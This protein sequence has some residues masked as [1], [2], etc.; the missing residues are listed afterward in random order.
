MLSRTDLKT[1]LPW[2]RVKSEEEENKHKNANTENKLQFSP[3]RYIL[4]VPFVRPCYSVKPVA[5]DSTSHHYTTMNPLETAANDICEELYYSGWERIDE[6]IDSVPEKDWPLPG[7]WFTGCE[8][9]SCS[10]LHV[11]ARSNPP[12]YLLEKLVKVF[13]IEALS[14]SDD[15]FGNTP[16]HYMAWRV[17]SLHAL[18]LIARAHPPAVVARNKR[19]D[20]PLDCLF[21]R[22]RE[23]DESVV[24]QSFISL[25]EIYP[26]AIHDIDRNGR[27]W[28]HRCLQDVEDTDTLTNIIHTLL[29]AKTDL[30]EMADAS[31]MIAL[32]SALERYNCGEVVKLLLLHT[33]QLLRS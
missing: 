23:A 5:L 19:F 1:D 24:A 18:E 13:G 32:H 15:D 10:A 28:L 4:C 6:I 7:V 22:G 9:D 27:T 29:A 11:A 20:T 12:L 8:F 33:P 16:L 21:K 31:G 30:T 14:I 2:S 25:L 3:I 17:R 26:E